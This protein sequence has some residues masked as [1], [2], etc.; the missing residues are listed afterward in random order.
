MS[1]IRPISK[2]LTVRWPNGEQS[3]GMLTI[4][5]RQG[6]A[7]HQ[8]HGH[9][10]GGQDAWPFTGSISGLHFEP[11]ESS[12]PRGQPPK[13]ARDIG[14]LIAYQVMASHGVQIEGS[15]TQPERAAK[16]VILDR[17]SDSVGFTHVRHVTRSIQKGQLH[18]NEDA[19]FILSYSGKRHGDFGEGLCGAL[20]LKGATSHSTAASISARG[21]AWV[22][23][24]G[25]RE[26]EFHK[27]VTVIANKGD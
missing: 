16:R 13:I 11:E 20:F 25:D 8:V 19:H 4:L 17:W 26:A 10:F 1:A 12:G 24:F 5:A 14:V 7:D 2:Q 27:C 15:T 22:W 21:P 9:I 6:H 23:H 18:V 3:P